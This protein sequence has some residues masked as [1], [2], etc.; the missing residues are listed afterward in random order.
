MPAPRRPTSIREREPRA[1][2]RCL[3]RVLALLEKERAESPSY[4][5]SPR[6]SLTVVLLSYN[7]LDRESRAFARFPL[8]CPGAVGMVIGRRSD[9][10]VR[11]LRGAQGA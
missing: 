5:V 10:K 8:Y 3:H 11:R 1:L 6:S 4:L 7:D 9:G 2:G